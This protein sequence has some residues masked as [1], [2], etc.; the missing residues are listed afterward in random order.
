P[1]GRRTDDGWFEV[2]SGPVDFALGSRIA[3]KLVVRVDR[4]MGNMHG[5]SIGTDPNGLVLVDALE[6][7]DLGAQAVADARCS[8]ATEQTACGV[9]GV[10]Y[11]GR[12]ADSAAFV[13]RLPADGL[14]EE[15]LDRRLFEIDHFNGNRVTG[16]NR[17]AFLALMEPLRA[18]RSPLAYWG[19]IAAAYE[20]LGDGHGAPPFYLVV[21]R[22]SAGMCL[23]LGEA[24]RLPVAGGEA[25]ARLPLVFYADPANPV[26]AALQP[27]DV[28]ETVDGM[29][30]DEWKAVAG[31]RLMHFGSPL[32]REVAI[33]PDI[34][35]A[36]AL[37]GAVL[38]FVRCP[39]E[40]ASTRACTREELQPVVVDFWNLAG[41][42]FW[43]GDV[44]GWRNQ[45]FACDFRFQ[46]LGGSV[47]RASYLY[48][49]AG[50]DGDVRVLEFNGV[51]DPSYAAAWI[52]TVSGALQPTSDLFLLDERVGY[53]GVFNTVDLLV[54]PFIDPLT[55]VLTEV[56]PVLGRDL[57]AS[58]RDAF[59]ECMSSGA[60][61]FLSCSNFFTYQTG[62]MYPSM[63][64]TLKDAKAALLISMDVSGN[65]WVTR[66]FKFRSTRSRVFGP[67]PTFGAFGSIYN[68]ASYLGEM[69]GGS[70]QMGDSLIYQGEPAVP[71]QLESGP[72]VQ[73]D[74]VVFQTQSDLLAGRDTLVE[75][76]KAWLRQ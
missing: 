71:Y 55:P 24:D 57:D 73:P 66:L 41:E 4:G 25:P 67:C 50:D 13:G 23:H 36:A 46:R 54:T 1:T 19:G 14:R 49:A 63:S 75:R 35:D 59:V 28:L 27:G 33:T 15:Y 51:P 2:S 40:T 38:G 7:A 10:C 53:G 68:L 39:A 56:F 11:L 74:E 29:P 12:C 65:D 34:P 32:A 18:V 47:P 21:E 5:A 31:A 48:A 70:A 42:A 30:V 8:L 43:S 3:P 17:D 26:A 9:V 58:T 52:E 62:D 61:D 22:P 76:A 69:T 64:G 44:S 72:G 60:V 37:L 45:R 6:V 16:R 20:K